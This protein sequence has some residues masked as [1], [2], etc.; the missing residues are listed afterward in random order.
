MR[1]VLLAAAAALLAA[2]LAHA[3]SPQAQGP[4]MTTNEGQAFLD[5]NAHAPGVVTLP[6]GLQYKVVKSGPKTGDTPHLR[7][8]IK[9]HYEGKLLNG[10]VFDS[11]I[12]RGTPADFPLRGLIPAWIE[13][14][15]LM[16]PGDEWIIWAPPAL[17]YGEADKGKIP[18][19][20]VLEFRMQLIGFTPAPPVPDNATFLS[21]NKAQP[22]VVTL[23]SGLQYK[24]IRSGDP[25]G[26]SPKPTDFVAVH[27]RG[28][29]LDGTVFDTTQGQDPAVFPVEGLI[30][31]WVE[32]LQLMHP[33]DQWTIWTPP[34]LAY[35]SKGDDV[36]PANSVLEFQML[37]LAYK[38][39]AEIEAAEAAE[40]EAAKTPP[41]K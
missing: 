33:G 2:P 40:Q 12:A 18:P 9:V 41:A 31:G 23:A 26:G 16:H 37:L 6:S 11:S 30:P 10:T 5:K 35:G 7:D 36:I 24:V 13:A 29:L 27:Y 38:S 15:Q 3:Q 17:A 21:T 32:A 19:N 34:E 39:A 25:A 8:T 14:V 22:G 4:A 1:L 28:A 20:S